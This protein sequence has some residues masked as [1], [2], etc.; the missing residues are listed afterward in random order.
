MLKVMDAGPSWKHRKFPPARLL[1]RR[2]TWQ[3]WERRPITIANYFGFDA[4]F[5][6]NS[7]AM[8]CV[9]CPRVDSTNLSEIGRFAITLTVTRS[10]FW[11]CP[12][13]A[14]A[15]VIAFSLCLQST[16]RHGV[17]DS[18]ISA[19]AGRQSAHGSKTVTVLLFSPAPRPKNSSLSVLVL[20]RKVECC[21]RI[22]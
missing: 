7:S 2:G 6:G 10:K 9:M 21:T 17:P 5:L 12:T 15:R 19:L 22:E 14:R 4:S 16:P 20:S 13:L 11:S 18:S 8:S 1:A 3:T